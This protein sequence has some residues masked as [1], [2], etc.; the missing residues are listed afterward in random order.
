MISIN[1]LTN[2]AY[3]QKIVVI[4][5]CNNIRTYCLYGLFKKKIKIVVITYN[6][7]WKI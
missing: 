2:I 7:S 4:S 6:N 1:I 5:C 3:K